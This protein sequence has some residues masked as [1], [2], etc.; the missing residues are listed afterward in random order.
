M[1]RRL[2]KIQIRILAVSCLMAFAVPVMAQETATA[3]TVAPEVKPAPVY[4][5]TKEKSTLKFTATQNNAPVEGKF[6]DFDADIAFDPDHLDISHI[7]VTV[8]VG[9][10]DLADSE[11][12]DTLLTADWLDAEA[13]PKAVFAST[14]ID[15]FPGTENFYAKGN[16][17]LRGVTMPATLNFTMEFMDDHSAIATGYATL[18]R[19][20]FG[21]GQKEWAK[22]DVVKKSVRVEFRIS[23]QRKS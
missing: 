2:L 11:T 22:D 15:R 21:V 1:S 16:L 23:A 6:K 13:H 8:D 14:A 19:G 4:M 5:I 10:L 9:S 3:T 12:K 7:R 20:D 18:Q 17:T